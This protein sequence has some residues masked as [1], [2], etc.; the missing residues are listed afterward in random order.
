MKAKDCQVCFERFKNPTGYL[1]TITNLAVEFE[2]SIDEANEF[3][4]AE[5]KQYLDRE[6]ECL[7]SARH[8]KANGSIFET[9]ELPFLHAIASAKLRK[10]NKR[11]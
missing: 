11:K 5:S 3:I 7:E 10:G 2:H 8:N 6:C 4:D 1:E 9:A